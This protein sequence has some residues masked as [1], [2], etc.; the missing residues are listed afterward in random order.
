MA[1]VKTLVNRY[2]KNKNPPRWEGEP[3]GLTYTVK[4]TSNFY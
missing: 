4:G 3:G 2:F 1:C